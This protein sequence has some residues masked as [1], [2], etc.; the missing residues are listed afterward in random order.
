MN[1][2]PPSPAGPR[3]AS[4]H[5]GALAIVYTVLFIAGLTFVS[6]FGLPLGVKPPY[7]PGPGE[8]AS[9]IVSYFQTHQP[10]VLICVFLQIGAL[11]PL[12]IYAATAVSRL[13]FLGVTAAGAYIAL[14]G[15]F[16][17]V[18]DG[19][20]AGF[21]TWGVIHSSGA[22][23]PVLSTAFYYV[24]FAFGGPGFSMPMGLLIAGISITAGF[25]KLLPKWIV[26][27]GLLLALAGEVSW[28]TLVLPKAIFLI[29]LVRFPGFIWLIAAGFALPWT[30]RRTPKVPT[31]EASA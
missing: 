13:R 12:G 25:G 3:H 31:V 28:L 30:L 23:N 24:S 4:P 15:G 21:T 6:G 20:A 7:W 8:P 18:F 26:G 19:M 17:T 27:F 10:E 29:P 1:S 5:L 11:I 9:V 2:Q 22:P 16:L 14:F